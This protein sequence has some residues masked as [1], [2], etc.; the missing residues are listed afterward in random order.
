MY[1]NCHTYYS[2]LYGTLSP[3]KLLDKAR[4]LG[5]EKFVLTDINNTSACIE[6]SRLVKKIEQ[7]LGVNKDIEPIFGI[8][9][10]NGVKQQFIGIAKNANGFEQLNRLLSGYLQEREKMQIPPKCPP[11]KDVF[12]IYPFDDPP[13]LEDL[14]PYEF[15]GI[16]PQELHFLRLQ[17]WEK[18]FHKMLILH[19]VTLAEKEDFKLHQLLRCIDE[20]TILSKL[21][22][23]VASEG[24][25]FLD[26]FEFCD[27]Y[28]DHDFLIHNT[29][30]ILNHCE[31][32]DFDLK[33]S[34]NKSV[35]S[36]HPDPKKALDEDY[37]LLRKLTYDG[38]ILRYRHHKDFGKVEERIE[39]ELK[40]IKK[41]KY[42]S[43]FLIN[44]DI[45]S[46]AIAKHFY[47]IGRGSG[48]NSIVA[49]CLKITDVDPLELDLYFERFLN[50]FRSAPPDFD[51]DFSW[52]DRDAVIQYIFTK[53]TSEHTCLQATYTTFQVNSIIRE[54]GK[55]Y[56]LPVEEIEK[57]TVIFREDMSC[58]EELYQEIMKYAKK[59][60]GF[61]KN[62]SIHAGGILISSKPIYTYT[63]TSHPPKGLPICQFDMH[64]SEDLGLYKFDILS[65][66][67][68]G[69]IKDTISIVKQNRGVAID[70]HDIPA[71]MADKKIIE[72]L[73]KGNLIGCFYVESPAMRMLLAKLE[74]KDYL[75]LV[76]ASSI[77]RPGVAQSGM[78]REY[79]RRHHLPDHG[80]SEAN[81]TIWNLMPDTYGVMVYQED[82]IKVAHRFA[83]LHPG[84]SDILRRG[85][86]GKYRSR[87]EFLQVK[88][89]FF[90][91]CIEMGHSAELSAEIWRQIE[92][93]AGYSFAKGHSASF[94]VE[95]YQSMFLKAH[96]PLEFMVGVINNFGGFYQTEF[97]V[98]EARKSGATIEAPCVNRSNSLT[99]IYGKSIFLGLGLL[100]S[101]ESK[102][103]AAILQERQLNG[104]FTSLADFTERISVSL[105]QVLILV[106]VGALRF[107]GKS[108][109]ALL[110]D[111]HFLLNKRP[112]KA[113]GNLLFKQKVNIDYKVPQFDYDVRNDMLDEL[114]FLGFTISPPFA[115]IADDDYLDRV[116]KAAEIPS[117]LN[118]EI[119][120]VGHL[121]TI[122]YA[123]TRQGIPM[124]FG[125]FLD[126]EG[127][128]I[129][130]VLFPEVAAR[131][132]FKGKG[133]YFLKGKVTEE[134]SFFT[135]EVSYMK[136]L[137]W[138]NAQ[139]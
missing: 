10:R 35:I 84:E 113:K 52:Q 72:H 128:W 24:E 74:C 63:A 53:Y 88:E 15:I 2:F 13:H 136:K 46:F 4:G 37:N 19:P 59:L 92:S 93:F 122:K 117:Y 57:L 47:Y 73:E 133:C 61:P 38:A 34:K 98:H 55:V 60:I 31:A 83:G 80:K 32:I 115:L 99:V 11:L 79:V 28:Q 76:A 118:K 42:V 87:E 97:Y 126:T 26:E 50:E 23:D 70:I 3:E 89:K 90:S 116:I 71:F 94:A 101:L 7:K 8:D 17:K 21:T 39:K 14:Q 1:L 114:E 105:E 121:V 30:Y 56:G 54:L 62:L 102:V 112:V 75:T 138:W 18:W 22:K 64:N 109:H 9:F 12:V 27:V 33:K 67:G 103:I 25:V 49:Y 124:Y 129:D 29:R 65:Q 119:S 130:T 106:R 16:K 95:S 100:K 48:A 107:T 51:I 111:V 91:N 96:Y 104:E 58:S 77:I 135:V 36:D 85:M 81:S 127:N 43:Y 6:V 110:W 78:M 41:Q 20:N 137:G 86:S 82:V 134:F 120:I 40:L 5:L 45:V 108:K 44:H 131:Y 123:K 139:E 132:S 66:R 125:T 69:H 68:L